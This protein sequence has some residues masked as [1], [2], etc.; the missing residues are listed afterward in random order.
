MEDIPALERRLEVARQRCQNTWANL[1]S[2]HMDGNWEEHHAANKE[3]L[4]LE[5]ELAAAKGEAY[6]EPCGFP[7]K[8]DF[9]APMP[10]LMANENRVMLAFLLSELDPEWDR[11]CVTLTSPS[12]EQAAP[13]GLVEFEFC[14][15]AKLGEP[16]DNAIKAHPLNGKGQNAYEAQRVIN[17]PWLKEIEAT[18]SVHSIYHPDSLHGLNHY[19]FWF[20]DSTFECVAPS[21]KV[22]THRTSMKTLLGLMVERLT[23]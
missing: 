14:F 2:I 21:F 19:I 18:N 10:H 22:E 4:L 3:L 20:H 5:R 11:S 13:L 6:A 8:W 7:L 17:S 23:C 15:C 12:D 1:A 16:S 9:G